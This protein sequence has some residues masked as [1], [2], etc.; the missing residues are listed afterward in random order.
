MRS[1]LHVLNYGL[2]SGLLA[3]VGISS[4]NASAVFP[5]A[6]TSTL[7]EFGLS[8]AFD[9]THYLVG[10]QGDA[11]ARDS[12]TAQLITADGTLVGP[13]ITTGERG[14]VPFVAFDGARFFMVWNGAGTRP[15]LHGQ[16]VDS[17]GQL[18]GPLLTMSTTQDVRELS[19]A[20]GNGQYLACWS[21]GDAVHGRIVTSEGTFAGDSFLISGTTERARE[22][23]VAF[24]GTH[25]LVVFNGTGDYRSHVYGQFVSPAGGLVGAKFLIDDSPDPS[26]NPLGVVFGSNTYLVLFNDETGSQGAGQWDIIGRRVS[27]AGAVA[28]DRLAIATGDGAQRFPFAAFDGANYLVSWSHALGTPDPDVVCRYFSSAGHPVG[29]PFSVFAAQGTNRPLLGAPLFAGGRFLILATLG[30]MNEDEFTTG[31][32]Y[33]AFLPRSPAQLVADY[34][35]EDSL[36]S[37][38]AGPP[39]LTYLGAA[40]VYID[41]L[42]PSGNQRVLRFL[43]GEGLELAGFTELVGT[44]YTLVALFRF[45][46]TSSWRRIFDF[47]NR[48]SDWGLYGYYGKLNFY[49]ITTGPEELVKQAE[50]IEVALSRD[51]EGVVRGYVDGSQQIAFNDSAGHALPNTDDLLVLFRDDLVVRN[52][53]TSGRINSLRIYDRALSSDEISKGVAE[54]EARFGGG[55]EELAG[56][57]RQSLWFGLYNETRYPWINSPLL[58]WVRVWLRQDGSFWFYLPALGFIWSNEVLFPYVYH[59]ADAVWMRFDP[60]ATGNQ[61]IVLQPAGG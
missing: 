28:P 2:L 38:V 13:R 15:G 26:D 45:D 39:A 18:D 42:F 40:Q 57:W 10:I 52:E 9:G 3:V 36:E 5:V 11:T 27:T 4:L 7:V 54:L 20:Y 61:W 48:S 47:R 43:A 16:F 59:R 32:V 1:H 34:Q 12:V 22:N 49:D 6:A 55:S 35:F 14:G 25:F 53:H 60:E 31:D 8:A 19:L 41:E 44:S 37:A 50:Y 46:E 58:G 51:A 23:A 29:D 24:D 30:V 17:A 33:G 21:A 56:D